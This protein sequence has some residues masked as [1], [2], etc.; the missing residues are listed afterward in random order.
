VEGTLDKAKMAVTSTWDFIDDTDGRV[1]DAIK[2]LTKKTNGAK[3]TGRKEIW[4]LA[5]LFE[6]VDNED[7]HKMKKL[8]DLADSLIHSQAPWAHRMALSGHRRNL[9]QL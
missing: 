6:Y 8:T 2:R 9:S 5:Y 3:S 7:I 4:D 1:A